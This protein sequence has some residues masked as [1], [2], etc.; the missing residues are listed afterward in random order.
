MWTDDVARCGSPIEILNNDHI[1]LI[2]PNEVKKS[3]LVFREEFADQT[4]SRYFRACIS[5]FHESV[6]NHP[7][8]MTGK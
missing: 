5:I 8:F 4:A 6:A 2:C 1:V 7:E 3:G